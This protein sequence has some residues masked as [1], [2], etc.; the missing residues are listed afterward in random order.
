M[1]EGLK[2]TDRL[3]V[4]ASDRNKREQ[5][6]NY[7]WND[8]SL[9]WLLSMYP[10]VIYIRY[11]V[12]ALRSTLTLH[13][14]GTHMHPHPIRTLY[15]I[16]MFI[17]P[18]QTWPYTHPLIPHTH[19]VPHSFWHPNMNYPHLISTSAPSLKV[20]TRGRGQGTVFWG[21]SLCMFVCVCV[22]EWCT[23]GERNVP[24]VKH[25]VLSV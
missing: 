15:P 16:H 23:G 13:T 3:L 9:T 22:C 20:K 8:R 4:K 25:C 11:T 21:Y 17:Y 24:W 6:Q 5:I 14:I 12:Y 1:A 2:W 10:H 19:T 18:P 7:T